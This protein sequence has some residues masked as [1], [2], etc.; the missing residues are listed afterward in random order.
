MII[1]SYAKTSRWQQPILS[2][3]KEEVMGSKRTI[4]YLCLCMV[5][6][7]ALTV[8][9]TPE[10]GRGEA[11]I[12]IGI[13]D[14]YTGA[15]AFTTKQALL[16]WG[17]AVD[18]FNARGGLNGRKIEIITRDDKFKPDE[19]LAHA[20]ELI[21]KEN[22]D[23]LG[24]TINSASALAVS[25]LAK[26]KKKIFMAHSAYTHRLTGEM[27][28]RYVFRSCQSADIIGQSGGAFAGSKPFKKWF[29]IGDDF[30]LG[31]SLAENFKKGLKKRNP[32]AV[33]VG[34]SW[35]KLGET[36]YTPY[37]SA[38]MAQKPD[39]V[40]GCFGGASHVP[41]PKQAKMFGLMDKV[42]YFHYWLADP[43]FAKVLKESY[44]VGVYSGLSYLWYYPETPAAKEFR[45]KYLEYTTKKGEPQKYPAE[46]VFTGYSGATF[47]IEAMVKA[48]SAKTENVIKALEGLTIQTA[49]GSLTMRACDHQVLAPVFWGQIAN[50]PN[51]PFPIMKDI[52]SGKV[53][54][55]TPTC[56]EIAAARKARAKK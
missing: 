55:I 25:E 11:P 31:H 29:I 18:E 45:Q 5:V 16:G 54:D 9:A 35:V 42:A 7:V 51:Y 36:D 10:M 56:E 32:D 28:H 34:E 47:L 6:T 43:M 33:I 23:F 20:R 44:P 1:S 12:R 13:I 52:Y 21:L 49:S 46:G 27:G 8:L 41:F 22:V 24:G 14:S 17:M 40:F 38:V 50:V 53:S 37:L 15:A 3:V 4:C 48:K 39:A 30:E 2:I 26:S 19:A